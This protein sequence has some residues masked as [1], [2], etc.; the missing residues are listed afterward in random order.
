MV[1]SKN[2]S[3]SELYLKTTEFLMPERIFKSIVC[4]NLYLG[5]IFMEKECTAY[6]CE[7]LLD[8]TDKYFDG[9]HLGT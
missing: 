3:D 7:D 1:S 4:D 6:M 9:G 8:L 2:N 5:S